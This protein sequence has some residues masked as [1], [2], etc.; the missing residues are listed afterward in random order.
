MLGR[1][2]SG[3]PRNVAGS[4]VA[5]EVKDYPKKPFRVFLFTP[6]ANNAWGFLLEAKNEELND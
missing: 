4:G 1:K 6:Q 3:P 2:A 5:K